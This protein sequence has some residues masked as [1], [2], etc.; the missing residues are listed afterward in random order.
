[1][2]GGLRLAAGAYTVN[3]VVDLRLERFAPASKEALLALFHKAVLGELREVILARYRVDTQRALGSDDFAFNVAAGCGAAYL[4][5]SGGVVI[6]LGQRETVVVVVVVCQTGADIS[7]AGCKGIDR[8]T[9]EK[10]AGKVGVVAAHLDEPRNVN[11]LLNALQ[12][13]LKHA[14]RVKRN[15]LEQDRLADRTGANLLLRLCV[16]RIEAAHEA[17]REALAAVLG[18]CLFDLLAVLDGLSQRLL[19]EDMLLGL[20]GCQARCLVGICA[21]CNNDCVNLRIVYQLVYIGVAVRYT[22]LLL[23]CLY[24]ALGAGAN[25]YN[26]CVR[27]TLQA[28]GVHTAHHTDT[29]DTETN[30]L[31]L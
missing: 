9:L 24:L 30:L 2:C 25:R 7:I 18:N 12:M 3:E 26:L 4:N 23:K 5:V 10:P 8:I 1:M 20:A 22:E 21:G 11:A 6:E 13:C 31:H 19:A 28:G 27:I 15:A 17:N 14:G 16:G 29:N